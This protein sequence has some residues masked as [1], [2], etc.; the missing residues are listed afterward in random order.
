MVYRFFCLLIFISFSMHAQVKNNRTTITI[1]VIE[2]FGRNVTKQELKVLTE[3]LSRELV[4]TGT[5]VV[6][7]P[8]KINKILVEFEVSEEERKT[9][10]WQIKIGKALGVDKVVAGSVNNFGT[11]FTAHIRTVNTQLKKIDKSA[12]EVCYYCSVDLLYANKMRNIARTLAG[13]PVDT[14]PDEPLFSGPVGPLVNLKDTSGAFEDWHRPDIKRNYVL[15]FVLYAVGSLFITYQQ[16]ASL[17]RKSPVNSSLQIPVILAEAGVAC[18]SI[19]FFAKARKSRSGPPV[20][21][22]TSSANRFQHG[23]TF[24][25][26]ATRFNPCTY[27]YDDRYQPRAGIHAGYALDIALNEYI[28]F[29]PELLYVQKNLYSKGVLENQEIKTS[30]HYLELPLS[31]KTILLLKGI[32]KPNILFGFSPGLLLGGVEKTINTATD[33]TQRTSL[34]TL[35]RF[36]SGLVYGIGF[37]WKIK[38]GTITSELRNSDGLFNL[39]N[40]WKESSNPTTR[41]F[42]IV[43]GYRF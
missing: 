4:K 15:G 6:I 39:G 27:N 1:A 18:L 31:F 38:T 26:T 23:L 8:E 41:V 5:F 25:I 40:Y 10:G 2:L 24:G 34:K 30:L 36:D 3:L 21:D 37:D 42:T 20:L 33:Q 13:L 22:N 19:P 14:S 43:V 7:E 28:A 17:A 16:I 32:C 29:H 11:G 35:K 9:V 12:T